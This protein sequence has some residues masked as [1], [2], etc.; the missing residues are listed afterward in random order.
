MPELAGQTL[1]L[2]IG[3]SA[4]IGAACRRMR[5]PSLLPLLLTGLAIGT[6]GAGLVDAT[7]LGTGMAALITVSIGLLIFEGALHLTAEEMGRAPRAVW[8]LITIGALATWALTAIAASLLLGMSTGGALLLGASVIVTGPTVV[9]PLLRVLRVTPR[10]HSVLSAEAILI[11]PIGV[12]ATITVLEVLRLSIVAGPEAQLAV[13][14]VTLFIVPLLGGAGAGIAIGLIGFALLRRLTRSGPPE[15]Q[16]LNLVALGLCMSCVGIGELVTRDAGLTAVAICGVILA[17]AR[18]LGATELRHFKEQLATIVIGTLFILLA[19][20]FDITR[21]AALSW[22]DGAFV[23]VLIFLIRPIGVLLSTA[24]S[25]L[26][27]RERVFA[28]T[29]A[30]RGIVALSVAAVAA[31]ELRMVLADAATA[32]PGWSVTSIAADADRLELISFTIIVS[33]VVLASTFSPLLAWATRLRVQNGHAVLMV[34][35]HALSVALARELIANGVSVRIVDSNA[36]RVARAQDA[37]VDALVGD[38]S[39]ARWMDDVGAPTDTGLVI[40]WTGNHDI[41]QIASRWA[42]R[43]FGR[44]HAVI[45]SSRPARNVEECVDLGQGAA[46]G[47]WIISVRQQRAVVTTSA[48]PAI[49]ARVLGWA[50]EKVFSPLAP[51]QTL[52]APRDGLAFI[53]IRSA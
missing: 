31:D 3:V 42:A 11:D 5:I 14:S 43:R 53:G 2:A 25:R 46:V 34:G 24:R 15:P 8:G 30:P 45:W 36:D 41:D 4:L 38:A 16:T 29:F 37:G 49:F 12:V 18:I 6:S 48:D 50:A 10:L 17:R 35:S 1:A 40:S 13:R 51:G 20:R 39:E 27:V 22:A 28:A 23:A 26:S 32:H 33:S 47:D 21:M 19:S 52:P 7:S 9:Q 44:E